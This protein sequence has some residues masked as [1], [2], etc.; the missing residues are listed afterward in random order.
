M[1]LLLGLVSFHM[2]VSNMGLLIALS[3]V[4]DLMQNQQSLL[5]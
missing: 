4:V 3:F 5:V 1:N 2:G